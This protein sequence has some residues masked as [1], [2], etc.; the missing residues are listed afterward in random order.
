METLTD[1]RE[2][3]E[4]WLYG[5]HYAADTI[6]NRRSMVGRFVRWLAAR[7][8]VTLDAINARWLLSY[9]G[10]LRATQTRFGAPATLAT[11]I[12][13]LVA[14]KSFLHWMGDVRA[15]DGVLQLPRRPHAIPRC[16]LTVADVRRVLDQPDVTTPLGL[17]DRAVLEVL[18]ATGLRR[19]EVTALDRGQTRLDSGTVTVVN[20][21]GNRD[22][23]VPLSPRACG[24][25]QQYLRD[26]R[27]S[28]AHPTAGDALFLSWRAR[29]LGPKHLSGRVRAYLAAAGIPGPGSTH[30]F[31]HAIATHLL[32]AG[33][34]IR[35]L[36]VFLGHA[37]LTT[38][39]DYTHVA[40]GILRDV[41]ARAHPLYQ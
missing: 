5:M 1:Q 37:K 4:R 12:Q 2:A 7:D 20:G 21:K 35:Y 23:Q 13:H 25:V 14:I 32:E 39:A 40:P 6:R 9:R 17:R 27:P 10:D 15:H 33:V 8:V 3:Y 38:T 22:R 29:R 34:D 16:I 26:G 30:R 18:Y 36:Q 11:Q 28:R 31:R 19:A 41:Y 24:W